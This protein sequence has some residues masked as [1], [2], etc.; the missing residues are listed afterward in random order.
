M[1]QTNALPQTPEET[2]KEIELAKRQFEDSMSTLKREYNELI[3]SI[4]DK[5]KIKK[6]KQV[7]TD[8]NT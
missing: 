7:W 4:E 1:T 3:K 2:Q 5:E 6:I 8:Q